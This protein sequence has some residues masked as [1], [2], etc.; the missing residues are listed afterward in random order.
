MRIQVF[1]SESDGVRLLTAT[2]VPARG[3]RGDVRLITGYDESSRSPQLRRQFP[4]T[5][6]V[7]IVEFGAPSRVATAGTAA[8]HVAG[9]YAAGLADTFAVTEHD[10]SQ[11]GVQVDLSPTGARRLFGIPLREISGQVVA[12]DDLLPARFRGLARRIAATAD[13]TSRLDIVEGVLAEC[14]VRAQVDTRRVDWVLRSIES[15][16]GRANIGGL[17]RS[18]GCS[19]K[20]LIALF[21]DQVGVAPRRYAR[22]VRFQHVLT[23]MRRSDS[24]DWADMAAL[25]GYADQPHLARDLKSFTGRTPAQLLASLQAP[26]DR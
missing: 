1:R 7:V 13:W 14:C 17:A 24:V 19:H 16:D 6:I 15:A 20:H 4:N 23:C 12:L 2:R 10:G 25:C 22:L 9:G 18:V 3:L 21:K 26:T 8:V 11:C 5:S